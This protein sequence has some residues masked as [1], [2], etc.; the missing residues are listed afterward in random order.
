MISPLDKQLLQCVAKILES[1]SS[2][3]KIGKYLF[4]SQFMAIVGFTAFSTNSK[5]IADEL[6]YFEKIGLIRRVKIKDN[7]TDS[8]HYTLTMEGKAELS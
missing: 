1:K 4:D 5:V 8:T 7:Y 3:V 2:V 6:D